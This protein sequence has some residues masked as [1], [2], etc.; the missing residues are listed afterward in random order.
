MGDRFL[1]GGAA[2]RLIAGLAPPFDGGVGHAC[3][4][5][6]AG[7]QSLRFARGGIGKTVA[8]HF[9]HASMQNLAPAFE[10]VLVC[11][12]LDQ[13]MLET[14]IG[15]GRQPLDQHD[16]GF[17]ELFQGR[18][19]SGVLHAG[20]VAQQRIRKSAANHGAN[21]RHLPGG[22]EPIKPGH[23][24]LLQRRWN[25]LDAA[26]LSALQ[27]EPRHFLDKQRH[28]AGARRDVFHYFLR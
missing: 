5:E 11:R 3:L 21:L 13:R 6:V 20:N 1:E 19:Q 24:R 22:T 7:R 9:R 4:R 16:V 14:V 27:Q 17:G 28:A 18:L 10:E 23:Q 26:L 15:V 25:S 2:Q 8:Q 12:V